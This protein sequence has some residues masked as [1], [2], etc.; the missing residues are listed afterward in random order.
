VLAGYFFFLITGW[1]G[2]VFFGKNV[3]LLLVINLTVKLNKQGL[4]LKDPP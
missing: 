3:N 4:V 2:S 1:V